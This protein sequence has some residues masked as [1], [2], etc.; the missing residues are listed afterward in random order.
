MIIKRFLGALLLSIGLPAMAMSQ[1]STPWQDAYLNAIP[2]I[3]QSPTSFQPIA[4]S[5]GYPFPTPNDWRL[6]VGIVNTE[7][8]AVV[9]QVEPGSAAAA[10]GIKINDIILAAGGA[11]LGYIDG[12]INDLADEIRRSATPQGQLNLLVYDSLGRTVR[13]VNAN[14]QSR[15]NSLEVNVALRDR[16]FLPVGSML[17]VQ[18]RN[19]TSPHYSIPGSVQTIGVSGSGPF[20]VRFNIDPRYIPQANMF[21][22]SAYIT[23]YN[24]YSHVLSRPIQIDSAS[25]T[26]PQAIS[27]DRYSIAGGQNV[28]VGYPTMN[29]NSQQI[30][31]VFEDYLGRQPLQSEL[32][33]WTDYLNRGNSIDDLK[34]G[35][36]T[37]AQFRDRFGGDDSQFIV[38]LFRAFKNRVPS[39]QELATLI[40]RLQTV[41]SAD[42]VAREIIANYR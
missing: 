20:N 29:N 16:E 25:L 37:S 9:N 8:G 27:L 39:N 36:L 1:S 22:L 35:V 24:Q 31:R 5:G 7:S 33:V 4:G 41:N 42:L 11:R 18:I 38:Y 23:S 3:T 28:N 40:N 21:E 2:S 30:Q 34:V 6:G 15:T 17:T 13:K 26:R 10:A 14:M 19:L 32:T 12:R